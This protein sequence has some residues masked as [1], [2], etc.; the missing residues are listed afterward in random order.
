MRDRGLRAGDVLAIIA[1]NCAEYVIAYLAA[2]QVGLYVVPVNWHLAPGEIAYILANSRAAMV[3]THERIRQRVDE[4]L[5]QME[6]PPRL[7]VSLTAGWTGVASLHEVTAGQSGSPVADPVRGRVLGYTSATTGR[8]KG[9]LLPLD[10]ADRVLDLMI[11]SRIALGTLPEEHVQLCAAMLYHGAPLESVSVA[12]HMG[13]VVVLVDTWDPAWIL[14][15]MARHAV[16]MAYI[17]PS[18]FTR[19]LSLDEG[20]RSR[21]ALPALRK[22]LHT[23]AACPVET[24]RRMIDWW[25]PIFWEAYGATEGSGTV[26]NSRD[27]L[28][29]PGTVG[30][31]IPGT[32]LRIL[33]EQG[34]DLPPGRTGLIYLTRYAGDRFEY[35]GDAEKTRLAH[36]DDFFTVGD[37]GYV[38]EEGFLF[39]CDRKSDMINVGGMKVYPS[40]IEPVL[41]AHP[42]VGD[43]VVFGVPD[44]DLGE[45]VVAAMVPLPGVPADKQFKLSVARF[46]SQH[47]SLTKL[48]RHFIV[49]DCVPR[50]AA[51]KVQRTKLKAQMHTDASRAAN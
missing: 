25:G 35:L 44:K 47:L 22:V 39:V 37:L 6:E 43:G 50:D 29:Y 21:H 49:I 40:E 5:A 9:V 33:D 4:V 1:P 11:G 26:V 14:Q 36:L 27:W 23:G 30:K 10:D 34:C 18:L 41:L 46:L 38:N 45:A 32:R 24:K 2:T 15:C 20:E 17:V 16:T 7:S 48:P 3:V 12:L 42:E 28:K 13:H 31:P 51:G 8:P 19:F